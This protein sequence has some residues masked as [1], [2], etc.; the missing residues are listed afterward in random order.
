ME[1]IPSSPGTEPQDVAGGPTTIEVAT[2]TTIEV[3]NPAALKA[4]LGSV[5]APGTTILLTSPTY[6]V[7]EPLVIPDDV[8][9][10]GAG[11][12]Q[13]VDGL[14]VGFHGTTTTI[15]AAAEL[16][17]NL[18]TLGDGSKVE[19]L[20]LQSANKVGL[21][22]AGR[23]G[24]VVAVASRD[25]NDSVSATIE[26][27]ELINKIN[28]DIGP[29]GPVGGA[30]LVY[31]RN[32][33]KPAPPD[34][35][36]HKNAQV[37]VTVRRSIVDTPNNGKAVFAMNFALG[38]QVTVKLENNV[39]RGP[40][41]VIGGLSRPDAVDGAKTTV[42]S[43]G[44]HYSPRSAS[45]VEAWHVV[46]GSSSPLG[47]NANTDSNSAVVQSEDD[48]IEN[49]R[50]GIVAIGGRRLPG[51]GTCSNNKVKLKLT[52]MKPATNPLPAAT[53]FEFAGARSFGALFPAGE[54]NSV[55]V[56][57][58]AGTR[59]DRLFSID[60][61]DAGVGTGNQLVFTGT[62]AAFGSL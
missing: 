15:I 23:G 33:Q 22:E 43:R 54:N 7:T 4:A 60:V 29:D 36:P 47:G 42:T 52:R 39:V 55:E 56:E 6:T 28:S 1:Q 20:I 48:Q 45:N 46:G 5:I 17:G 14:L 9:L 32:P 62:L 34:P 61:H 2:V 57:V 16:K 19:K 10:Q 38:G 35:Q 53:D 11:M 26:E 49:F 59:P 3:A 50:V 51:L 30:V 25:S 41:D 40:L 44:N 18:L 8:T 31:T 21:D 24:N 13:V 27:C 58:L 12:M 37:T